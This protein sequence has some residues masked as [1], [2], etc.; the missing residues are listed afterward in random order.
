[1]AVMLDG[2]CVY[3]TPVTDDVLG[4]LDD[5]EVETTLAQVEGLPTRAD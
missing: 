3:D 5:H 2:H 4:W 1:M